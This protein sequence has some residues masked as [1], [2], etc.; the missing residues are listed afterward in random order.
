MQCWQG[1]ASAQ[2]GRTAA[3]KTLCE[4]A[5][6]ALHNFACADC[7]ASN[8]LMPIVCCTVTR[9]RYTYYSRH[10]GCIDGHLNCSKGTLINQD[11]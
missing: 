9:F 3:C 5:L 11:R 6:L 2:Q 1:G 7:L 8:E 10:R 4:T